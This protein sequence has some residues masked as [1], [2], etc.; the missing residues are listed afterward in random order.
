[1]FDLKVTFFLLEDILLFNIKKPHIEL[2]LENLLLNYLD[3]ILKMY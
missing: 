1:M 2:Q 3:L